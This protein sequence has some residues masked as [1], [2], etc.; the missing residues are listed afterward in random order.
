MHLDRFRVDRAGYTTGAGIFRQ[1]LWFFV[2]Q[3]LVASRLAPFS[4]LKVIVLRWFGAAI[5]AGVRVKPGVRVKFPW[6][7]H[8]GD[9]CWLGEDLWI[10][11]LAEVRIGSHCC[12]S[13]GAYLCTGSHDW[14]RDTFDLITRPIIVEDHAWVGARA[15]VAPG[16]VIGEGAILAL[17]S[18]ATKSLQPWTIYL[19]SPAHPVRERP[20]PARGEVLSQNDAPPRG[21]T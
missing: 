2:G 19:G 11:N 6:R 16:V 1:V 3:P 13:Q 17:G 12:L 8:V 7:L 14:S 4:R 10:D 5:G 15:V 21:T 9:H 20:Q 18:V